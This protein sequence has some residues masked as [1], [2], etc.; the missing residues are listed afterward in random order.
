[1]SLVSAPLVR[2]SVRWGG[3][4]I[5]LGFVQ[6]AIANAIVQSRYS[7]YSLLTNYVSDLGN[8]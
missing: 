7:G 6:F 5:A 8:T 3:M 1:M 2:R 4:L